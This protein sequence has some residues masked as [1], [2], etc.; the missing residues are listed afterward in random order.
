M[1]LQPGFVC[2]QAGAS[3]EWL[4]AQ[5]LLVDTTKGSQS[6]LRTKRSRHPASYHIFARSPTVVSESRYWSAGKAPSAAESPS[7]KVSYTIAG[8]PLPGARFA[9]RNRG[10]SAR[11]T[12]KSQ[13]RLSHP[14]PPERLA[15]L[16]VTVLFRIV[17]LMDGRATA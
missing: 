16:A 11:L 5:L 2:P 8:K 3:L 13:G 4:I 6:S 7:P 9:W 14:A 1:I 17:P 12:S 10:R 15:E